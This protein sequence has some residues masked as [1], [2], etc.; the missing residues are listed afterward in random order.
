VLDVPL[1]SPKNS[2]QQ[3]SLTAGTCLGSWRVEKLIGRGGMGEVYAASRADGAFEQRV[4]LKLLR[5]EAAGEMERFHA[6]R[7]I[8]ARLEH[9]GIARILDGGIAPD[10]R[11]YTVM[12]YVEGS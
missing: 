11:P 9:P 5:Y 2:V 10:G 3:A 8:L 7:R 6:E 1:Y 4:A 12:E